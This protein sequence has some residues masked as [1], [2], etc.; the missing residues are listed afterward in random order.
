MNRYEQLKKEYQ[1]VYWLFT[2]NRLPRTK[3]RCFSRL[4]R[5]F[6]Q[7]WQLHQQEQAQWQQ[8]Q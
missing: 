1:L 2:Q 8:S 5:I 3:A 4:M 7:L 6:E